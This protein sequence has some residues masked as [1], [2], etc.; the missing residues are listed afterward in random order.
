ME[1]DH[2]FSANNFLFLKQILE[3]Y[4]IT[5]DFYLRYL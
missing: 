1:T 4:N 5:E 2:Y 3:N